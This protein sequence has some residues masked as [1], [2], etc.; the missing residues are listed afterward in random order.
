VPLPVKQLVSNQK[1]FNYPSSFLR[2]HTKAF[3][4]AFSDLSGKAFLMEKI[5]EMPLL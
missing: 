2:G 1:E 5:W 3:K 4:K